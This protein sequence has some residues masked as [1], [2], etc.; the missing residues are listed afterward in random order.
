MQLRV[1]GDEALEA[2]KDISVGIDEI[3]TIPE[4]TKLIRSKEVGRQLGALALCCR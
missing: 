2:A 3:I 4:S 1:A